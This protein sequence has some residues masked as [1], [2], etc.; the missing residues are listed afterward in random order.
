MTWLLTRSGRTANLRCIGIEQLDLPTIA[1]SLSQ[2]N[3]F[4][5]HTTRSISE[6]E[7]ALN[8]VEVMQREYGVRDPAVLAAGLLNNAYK[9]LSGDISA[10]MKDLL[11][12]AWTLEKIR[13]QQ[14]VL[15]QLG[16]WIAHN[17]NKQLIEGASEHVK[18]AEREQLMYDDGDTWPCQV[19]H[20][21][22]DWLRLGS[23]QHP[24]AWRRAY[25]DRF[26]GFQ[27]E[28]RAALDAIPV[29][30]PGNASA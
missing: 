29:H 13:I 10:G 4:V 15:R 25:L 1:H 30:Q 14:S 2:I 9:T 23:E 11:G 26:N 24:E 12:A 28:I 27:A 7:H 6:A 17:A 5:G 20:P 8:V 19:T 21:A 22:P 18:S 3:R 16:Y